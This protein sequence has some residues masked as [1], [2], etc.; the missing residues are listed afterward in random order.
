MSADAPTTAAP[1]AAPHPLLTLLGDP[2]S[3]AAC[4]GDSCSLPSQ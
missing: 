2:A 1:A 3:A 4:D